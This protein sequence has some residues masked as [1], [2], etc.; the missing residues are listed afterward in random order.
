MSTEQTVNCV[1]L[2][3]NYDEI[4]K[5]NYSSIAL[6][7]VL[8]MPVPLHNEWL[9]GNVPLHLIALISGLLL[10]TTRWCYIFL[11][12]SLNALIVWSEQKKT[13]GLIPKQSTKQIC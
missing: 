12:F 6:I 3:G 5:I 2:T 9:Q 4:K 7:I 13:M 11:H 8:D 10:N 1:E